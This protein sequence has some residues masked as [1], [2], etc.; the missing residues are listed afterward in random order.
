VLAAAGDIPTLEIM[1]AV[2]WLRK[3]AP[4]LRIRVVNVVDLM[5][6]FAPA[7]HPHGMSDEKFVDLFTRSIDVIFAFHGY[8]GAVHMLLHRRPNVSRFHVRGYCEEGTT[9]TPFDMVVLNGMS[10]FHLCMEALRR[11]K[12]PPPNVAQLIHE[13]EAM[14]VKHRQ[15]VTQQFE[16][17]PE[18]S[19]W[20]WSMP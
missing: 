3:K 18:I 9:T 20:T 8:A 4:S 15:Y 14:L 19:N 2:W 17:L 10:R 6:I 1:A 12:R 5:T 13:C 16:D 7:D 11:A